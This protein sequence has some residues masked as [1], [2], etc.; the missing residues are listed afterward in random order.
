MRSVC[1]GASENMDVFHCTNFD[2]G[3]VL[4][5]PGP[6]AHSTSLHAFSSVGSHGKAGWVFPPTRLADLIIDVAYPLDNVVR[7]MLRSQGWSPWLCTH[8]WARCTWAMCSLTT[9]QITFILSFNVFHHTVQ[10]RS[11]VSPRPPWLGPA[12]RRVHGYTGV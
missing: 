7:P 4:L 3:R 10:G 5:W 1:P 8:S 2:G 9:G 11:V 6:L 12:V